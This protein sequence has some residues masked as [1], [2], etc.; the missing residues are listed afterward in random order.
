ML[1]G[2]GWMLSGRGTEK[3]VILSGTI[4]RTCVLSIKK[5]FASDFASENTTLLMFLNPAVWGM[6]LKQGFS[7]NNVTS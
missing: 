1:F 3:C 7:E 2:G 6:N 5:L 4:R